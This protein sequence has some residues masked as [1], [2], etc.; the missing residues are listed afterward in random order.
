MKSE[1]DRR[2]LFVG[3]LHKDVTS[4]DLE[5]RFGKF[6]SVTDVNVRTKRDSQ[7]QVVNVFAYVDINITE[8][9]FKK[10]LSTYN[11]A[12]W[13]G[14]IMK[15]QVAKKDFLTKLAKERKE[16]QETP[17]PDIKKTRKLKEEDSARER[18]EESMKKAG[19]EDFVMKKAVPGTP[20]PGETNWVVGK[21]GR[22]L[23]IMHM[24]RK[25]KRSTMTFDPSKYVHHVRKFKEDAKSDQIIAGRPVEYL[26]WHL[27]ET[28]SDMDRKRMGDFPE[29]SR[30]KK[31]KLGQQEMW[32]KDDMSER[33]QISLSRSTDETRRGTGKFQLSEGDFEIVGLNTGKSNS[34]RTD[35]VKLKPYRAQMQGSVNFDQSSSVEGDQS[36]LCRDVQDLMEQCN[37]ESDDDSCG[38]ADTDDICNFARKGTEAESE[39]QESLRNWAEEYYSTEKMAAMSG[40][41]E[42]FDGSGQED[43]TTEMTVHSTGS[44]PIKESRR[45]TTKPI[46]RFQSVSPGRR[47]KANGPPPENIQLG[48][49]EENDNSGAEFDIDTAKRGEE[50]DKVNKEDG[51]NYEDGA[52][53]DADDDEDDSI[54][55]DSNDAN[56]DTDGDDDD[57]EEEEFEAEHRDKAENDDINNLSPNGTFYR[58]GGESITLSDKSR[59]QRKT[60]HKGNLGKRRKNEI[61][62]GSDAGDGSADDNASNTDDQSSDLDGT[63]DTDSSESS[64]PTEETQTP[65]RRPSTG[66]MVSEARKPTLGSPGNPSKLRQSNQIRLESVKKRQ[67]AILTQKAAI[68]DALKSLDLK[69]GSLSVGHHV[70]FDSDDEASEAE[71]TEQDQS[72]MSKTGDE[73]RFKIKPQFQ[74]KAGEKLLR[75]QHRIGT[76]SR[77]KLGEL[78]LEDEDESNEEDIGENQDLKAEK[79]KAL[80][81]LEDIVGS[82]AMH[83][84]ESKTTS[85][86]RDPSRLRYDPTREDHAHFERANTSISNASSTKKKDK[87]KAETV[88][89]EVSKDV[90]YEVSDLTFTGSKDENQPFRFFGDDELETENDDSGVGFGTLQKDIQAATTLG[91]RQL[92]LDSS[93]SESEVEEVKHDGMDD[94]DIASA[95]DATADSQPTSAHQGF[96]FQPDDIRLKTGP[97]QFCRKLSQEGMYQWF[98]EQKAELQREFKKRHQRALRDSKKTA[99]Q[100][101]GKKLRR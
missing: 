72:V 47:K 25:D 46:D 35:L 55:R 39:G 60:E 70:R 52:D 13:K 24:R 43:T 59:V 20:I 6:G 78:F 73:D 88:I 49:A 71:R 92:A 19:V 99:R 42:E 40:G 101:P 18:L 77:F 10:C 26:T 4:A 23:P 67:A 100:S 5:Q 36:R 31:T 11:N 22:V 97:E 16:A 53:E 14:H 9:N 56:E 15:V 21:F 1:P 69:G 8:T 2:R 84:L 50:D 44:S 83:S 7:G 86:F 75:L 33:K 85:N 82:Q 63:S 17:E 95:P 81:V 45:T 51:D 30:K 48:S 62:D 91:K 38:S 12:K 68:Q 79:Q 3:G 58:S 29:Y 89:P 90:Y 96:F 66:N 41:T 61:V 94:M 28:I 37:L 27:P 32:F 64:D 80:S 76:D 65:R 93:D 87:I 74:G 98:E 54:S 57:D 34:S